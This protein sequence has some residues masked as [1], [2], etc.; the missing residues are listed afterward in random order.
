MARLV[1]SRQVPSSFE[2]RAPSFAS[3]SSCCRLRSSTEPKVLMFTGGSFFRIVARK[4]PGG[5]EPGGPGVAR[6]RVQG[7]T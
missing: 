3:S 6:R 5:L 1:E 7:P 2:A 4:T